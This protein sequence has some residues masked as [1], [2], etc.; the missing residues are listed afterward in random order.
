MLTSVPIGLGLGPK[1][2][3]EVL[4]VPDCTALITALERL[5]TFAIG[6]MLKSPELNVADW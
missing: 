2:M 5:A 4:V 1:V 3:L 6:E